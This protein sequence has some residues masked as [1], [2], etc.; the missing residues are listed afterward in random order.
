MPQSR[1]TQRL[2][3]CLQV[4]TAGHELTEVN[5]LVLEALP[6][7]KCQDQLSLTLGWDRVVFDIKYLS[8]VY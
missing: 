2:S 8:E 4:Q 7:H 5:D 1:Q 3:A 6:V